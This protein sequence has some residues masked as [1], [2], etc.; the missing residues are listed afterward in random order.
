MRPARK[1]PP[2]RRLRR[3]MEWDL[4]LIARRMDKKQTMKSLQLD[5]LW[6]ALRLDLH[7]APLN[8][9][10]WNDFL[11]KLA[12]ALNAES[13]S[14]IL[15]P[16]TGEKLAAL[17]TS[18]GTP[19]GQRSYRD[20]STLDPFVRLPKEKVITIDEFVT[21]E[22]LLAS[23]F[24]QNYLA[25]VNVRHVVGVDVA[26]RSFDARLRLSRS[27]KPGDF[28]ATEKAQL[29]QVL[30]H[31]K[32]ALE[33]LDKLATA[34]TDRS[35]YAHTLSRLA[36]GSI[37]VAADGRILEVS[38]IAR[39]VIDERD[40]L[41]EVKG[42]LALATPRETQRL[43][44]IIRTVA[45]IS[46]DDRQPLPTALRAERPSGRGDVGLVVQPAPLGLGDAIE[47]R[48]IILLSDPETVVS[49]S[50][51]T[52]SALFGLTAAES[53]ICLQLV[54]GATLDEAGLA[55][56]IKRNTVRA[57]LRSIF[58]KTGVD[59]QSRLV[60]LI[61]NSVVPVAAQERKRAD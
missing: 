54:N 53:A 19:E 2:A 30:P 20:Q 41:Q 50:P 27:E 13:A 52:I 34:E 11:E 15:S 55:L 61:L 1:Q 21:T 38:G 22:V 17:F 8:G 28:T 43:R 7:R 3:I 31:L 33:T 23:A 57:H 58:E 16:S 46:P 6:P 10:A 60:R 49:V 42:Y 4:T 26:I 36:I 32:L 44:E 39:A 29:E 48:A 56:G 40:G 5:S 37:V 47:P 51:E 45:N 18:G 14:F 35:L 9:A 12:Q 25:P 59:R 24:Y